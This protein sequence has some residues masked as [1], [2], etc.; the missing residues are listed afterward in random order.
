MTPPGRP[1]PC[2]RKPRPLPLVGPKL[3]SSSRALQ[4]ALATNQ[5][6]HTQ[7]FSHCYE[8]QLGHLYY[9]YYTTTTLLPHTLHTHTHTPSSLVQG[10]S[11]DFD[12]RIQGGGSDKVNTT[13]LSG[14]AKINRIFHERF[15]FELHKAWVCYHIIITSCHDVLNFVVLD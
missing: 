14:G 4:Q 7:N 6:T 10:Y 12:R 1:R 11:A 8:I 3:S 2:S 15:P 5:A 13:E 9:Y